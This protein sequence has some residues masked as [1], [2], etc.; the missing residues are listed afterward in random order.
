[1]PRRRILVIETMTPDPSRDSGSVRLSQIFALLHADGWQIDFLADDGDAS[2]AD[3]VRLGALGV[4]I[5]REP[6]L[7]WLSRE[8]ATLDAVML[9]RLPVAD[10]YIDVVRRFAP[11]ARTVF[12]TVDLHFIRERRAA[13]LTGNPTLMRQANRSRERELAMVARCD[14]TLVVSE[15]ERDVLAREAPAANVEVLSNIHDAHGRRHGFGGR[16]GML[17][18]GGFGH[19]PNEDAVRWF[20]TEVLPRVRGHLPHMQLHVVGDIDP[21]ARR[22]IESDAVIVHGRVADLAPLHEQ[23]LVSIAPLRFGAGV[24]GKVNQ[25][26]SHGLPVVLT[27]IAAEGMHLRDGID[28]LVADT[29]EA[30]AAAIIRLSSNEAIWSAMSDASVENVRRHFSVENARHALRHALGAIA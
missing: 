29:P 8:G 6:A 5:V 2:V 17:F 15:E 20:V 1:M 14:I 3:A 21:S 12:D 25:A 16:H 30:F 27:T 23:A 19:P 9:C 18:V 26:M 10:Q 13:D 11:R 7:R 24:K 22:A 28:A 4:R